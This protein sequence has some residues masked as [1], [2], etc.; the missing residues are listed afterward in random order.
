MSPRHYLVVVSPQIGV[1]IIVVHLKG[2]TFIHHL[3]RVP[4]NESVRPGLPTPPTILVSWA[5]HFCVPWLLLATFGAYWRGPVR[6]IEQGDSVEEGHLTQLLDIFANFDLDLYFNLGRSTIRAT[7]LFMLPVTAYGTGLCLLLWAV[8]RLMAPLPATEAL[9][10]AWVAVHENRHFYRSVGAGNEWCWFRSGMGRGVEGSFQLILNEVVEVSPLD[11][12]H[13]AGQ[14]LLSDGVLLHNPVQLVLHIP[15][16]LIEGVPQLHLSSEAIDLPNYARVS[17]IRDRL[18]DQ[19]LLGS[20]PSE[21]SPLS[22]GHGGVVVG[23]P[24]NVDG[25]GVLGVASAFSSSDIRVVSVVLDILGDLGAVFVVPLPV[26]WVRDMDGVEMAAFKLIVN[27][28]CRWS[29]GIFDHTLVVDAAN[30]VF[31]DWKRANSQLRGEWF[32]GGV[33]IDWGIDGY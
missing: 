26:H 1:T 24:T 32:V 30:R 31:L 33:I 18:V 28:A 2:V 22:R 9:D 5:L 16:Q 19:E 17:H 20:T 8:L 6:A 4:P 21:L 27:E 3:A 25:D 7:C 10:L 13:G 23:V 11:P 12:D 29:V 15:A 14:F